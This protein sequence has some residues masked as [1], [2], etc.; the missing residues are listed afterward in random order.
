[1]STLSELRFLDFLFAKFEEQNFNLCESSRFL[2][3]KPLFLLKIE[4]LHKSTMSFSIK[5][6]KVFEDLF[7]LSIFT[8]GKKTELNRDLN[9][10]SIEQNLFEFTSKI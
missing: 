5:F 2:P 9:F 4:N 7:D 8:E 10:K 6:T 1:M 3:P